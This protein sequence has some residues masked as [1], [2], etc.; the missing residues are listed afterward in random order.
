MAGFTRIPI[1]DAARRCG[2]VLDDRT[3]RRTEVE[4]ACPFCGDHGPGKYHLS[5]NTNRDVYRSNL[6][7]A[8]GNSV[9]LYARLRGVSNSKAVWELTGGSNVY[10]FPSRPIPQY[11]EPQPAEL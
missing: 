4:A 6:C 10:A 3:L 7:G 1:V 2:L 5:L 8:S 11:T 9:T